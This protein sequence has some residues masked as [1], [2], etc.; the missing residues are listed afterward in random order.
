MHRRHLIPTPVLMGGLAAVLI[1]T[2]TVLTV[3]QPAVSTPSDDRCSRFVQESRERSLFPTGTGRRVAVIGDS[4]AAGLA[5]ENPASA[6][7]SRLPGRVQVFA[8]SGSGFGRYSSQ[9]GSVS[10]VDRVGDVIATSP[11]LVVVEGGLNDIGESDAAI[12]SGLRQLLDYLGG[13]PVLVVGPPPAPSR[14]KGAVRV[15]GILREA[16]RRNGVG[17]LSMIDRRFSYLGDNLHLTG[18]S[19]QAFG[20]LVAADLGAARR[21]IR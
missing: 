17:Y 13:V 19:H 2:L 15:D 6:W 4:Y 20:E 5:L 1:G 16:A 18:E 3:V 9:C 12:R 8:F 7:T 14:E 11:D 10:Y 21:P